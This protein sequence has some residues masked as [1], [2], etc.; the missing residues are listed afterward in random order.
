MTTELKIH[1]ATAK[2]AEAAGILLQAEGDRYVAIDTRFAPDHEFGGEAAP[3]LVEMLLAKRAEMEANGA[4]PVSAERQNAA[5]IESE[6]LGEAVEVEDDEDDGPRGSVISPERKVQYALN[7]GHC[8]DDVASAFRRACTDD[9]GNLDYQALINIGH[10][11]DV[12]VAELW[13]SHN[14]GMQRMNLSNVL[15]GKLRKGTP[16]VIG[17]TTFEPV[18]DEEGEPTGE[19]TTRVARGALA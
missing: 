10:A 16:V 11:N 12:E 9:K 6:D 18:L 3:A 15:R 13:G 1:H 2:K 4:K 14:P 7:D 17:G 19:V 8:G 5:H